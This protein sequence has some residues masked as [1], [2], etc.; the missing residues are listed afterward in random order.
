MVSETGAP[1]ADTPLRAGDRLILYGRTP[2]VVGEELERA[3]G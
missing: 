1:P 2:R 3:G